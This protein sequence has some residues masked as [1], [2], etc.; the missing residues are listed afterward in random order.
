[1]TTTKKTKEQVLERRWRKLDHLSPTG[2][3]V[4]CY[5]CSGMAWW[6]LKDIKNATSHVVRQVHF[7][8]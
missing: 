1:M 7:Y 5:S 3:K 6:L 2:G 8:V 4:K